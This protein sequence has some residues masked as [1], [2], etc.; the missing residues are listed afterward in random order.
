MDQMSTIIGQRQGHD[1]CFRNKDETDNQIRNYGP[2]IG[3][4]SRNKKKEV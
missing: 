1:N 4:L 3:N 2:S